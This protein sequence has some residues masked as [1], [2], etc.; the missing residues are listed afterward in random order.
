MEGSRNMLFI[1]NIPA[2]RASRTSPF[3]SHFVKSAPTSN[4]TPYLL[5]ADLPICSL[6]G[7]CT[8]STLVLVRSSIQTFMFVT[9]NLSLIPQGSRRLTDLA[10]YSLAISGPC[11]DDHNTNTL[12][13]AQSSAEFVHERLCE[14][15]QSIFDS[16][17][18]RLLVERPKDTYLKR[19]HLLCGELAASART[20]HLCRWILAECGRSK[21][22][23]EWISAQGDDPGTEEISI[24]SIKR[25]EA[26]CGGYEKER[27]QMEIGRVVHGT[28][29]LILSSL[30]K[31]VNSLDGTVLLA[32]IVSF[33][34]SP[35]L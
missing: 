30:S 18:I 21:T 17:V 13:L 35:E 22:V 27:I 1:A 8:L 16:E 12:K 28:M 9:P 5:Y 25:E 33:D 6:T 23:T 7:A 4:A 2:A 32:E 24:Q 29:G 11:D 26:L 34:C 15:C 31:P 10:M 3:K 19:E 20:C 14:T